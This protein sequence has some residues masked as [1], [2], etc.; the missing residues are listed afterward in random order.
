MS[1]LL[2]LFIIFYLLLMLFYLFFFFLLI[3]R[4]PRSTR[5]DTLFPYT[6][7]FRSQEGRALPV[8][9]WALFF[10]HG[11]L[12]VTPSVSITRPC[13]T[14]VTPKSGMLRHLAKA[15]F[16]RPNHHLRAAGHHQIQVQPEILNGIPL[17]IRI[18]RTTRCA[19]H[20]NLLDQRPGII[21]IHPKRL[22]QQI[23][24]ANV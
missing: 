16:H 7:L 9:L 14:R 13:Q 8:L 22:T 3:R 1:L 4:P 10:K 24:R 6:T 21:G 5:T 15:I 11:L 2:H 18:D 12:T 17:G 19:Y 20:R 23:G